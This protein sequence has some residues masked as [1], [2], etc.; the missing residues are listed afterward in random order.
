MS[1]WFFPFLRAQDVECVLVFDGTHF[2]MDRVAV[3][4]VSVT[5]LFFF[6]FFRFFVSTRQQEAGGLEVDV[7]VS[8]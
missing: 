2:V 7:V 4:G 6:V 8:T 3:V 5:A 1:V